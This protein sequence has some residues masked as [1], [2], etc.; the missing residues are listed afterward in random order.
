MLSLIRLSLVRQVQI[1]FGL[2]AI[3]VAIATVFGWGLRVQV[4]SYTANVQKASAFLLDIQKFSEE[5]YHLQLEALRYFHDRGEKNLAAFKGHEN[6]IVQRFNDVMAAA[7]E[8]RWLVDRE[9]AANLRSIQV[10]LP[11]LL[12]RANSQLMA[13]IPTET[14]FLIDSQFNRDVDRLLEGKRA[15][16]SSLQQ[17]LDRAVVLYRNAVFA[18]MFLVLVMLPVMLWAIRRTLVHP[19]RD[20]A[21]LAGDLA[22][23]ENFPGA[24]DRL[25]AISE[26]SGTS[27]EIRLLAEHLESILKALGTTLA[28]V[29]AVAKDELSDPILE[30]DSP[31]AL[32]QSFR[33]MTNYLQGLASHVELL[34]KGEFKNPIASKGVL[35]TAFNNLLNHSNDDHEIRAAA[36]LLGHEIN[37]LLSVILARAELLEAAANEG[38]LDPRKVAET[39]AKIRIAGDRITGVSK[40]LRDYAKGS[41]SLT[42]TSQRAA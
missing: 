23:C 25:R 32:G 4:E 14:P 10:V 5:R 33:S 42:D 12:E 22:R 9:T 30:V 27:S 19:V 11:T 34:A 16:L 31:G 37:N 6:D 36:G 35:A 38:E 2:F 15:A 41:A 18:G 24:K 3:L 29:N 40:R 21:L 8:N 28:K 13:G 39:A 26:S 1:A 17:D 20:L 7:N